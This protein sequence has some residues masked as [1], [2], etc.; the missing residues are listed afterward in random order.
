MGITEPWFVNPIAGLISCAMLFF[1]LPWLGIQWL[2]R[3]LSEPRF[4]CHMCTR[5][6]RV[7]KRKQLRSN[8][9]RPRADVCPRCFNDYL[10]HDRFDQWRKW[11]PGKEEK[12]K[13]LLNN[14]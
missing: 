11:K 10:W 6:F 13:R 5:Q 8:G 3:R 2:D 9:G 12:W 7:S 1:F 14:S 4:T